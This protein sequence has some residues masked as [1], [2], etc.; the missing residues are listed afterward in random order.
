MVISMSVKIWKDPKEKRS[1]WLQV[2]V[3]GIGRAIVEVFLWDGIIVVIVDLLPMPK[4]RV[5][6]GDTNILI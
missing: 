6:K 5:D 2:G 1:R 3:R 4:N